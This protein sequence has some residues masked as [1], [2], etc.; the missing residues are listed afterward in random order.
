[1]VSFS[2]FQNPLLRSTLFKTPHPHSVA[3]GRWRRGTR[4]A[5]Y[6]L[7]RSSAGLPAPSVPGGRQR[8]QRG[9]DGPRCCSAGRGAKPPCGSLIH[10]VA[11]HRRE[12][13]D[14][15]L[16]LFRTDLVLVEGLGEVLDAGVP[17]G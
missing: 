1:M 2:L 5:D 9:P 16:L 17:L 8:K 13:A 15:L 11:L 7:P 12:R 6:C 3:L 14:Q 4:A 10:D